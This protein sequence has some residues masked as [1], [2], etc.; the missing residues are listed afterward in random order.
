M[1]KCALAARCVGRGPGTLSVPSK[2]R[3]PRGWGN[4]FGG[5]RGR[6]VLGLVACATEPDAARVSAP[7]WI[8]SGSLRVCVS[9]SQR[10]PAALC[11]PRSGPTPGH[12]GGC[13][14]AVRGRVSFSGFWGVHVLAGSECVGGCGVA[15]WC[16]PSGLLLSRTRRKQS[17]AAC[18]TQHAVLARVHTPAVCAVCV[19]G[20]RRRCF[21]GKSTLFTP[22]RMPTRALLKPPLGMAAAH[23]CCGVLLR[24]LARAAWA[25]VSV[26]WMTLLPHGM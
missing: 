19:G 18:T 8:V 21:F 24:L 10:C 26:P 16:R 11:W 15:R 5:E 6:P 23:R 2:G 17:S 25:S 3:R 13:E 20:C 1:L 9:R 22:A 7:R 14:G 4:G 12:C